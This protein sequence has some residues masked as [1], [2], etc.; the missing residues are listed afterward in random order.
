MVYP[1]ECWHCGNCRIHCPA[2]AVQ[3]LFPLDMLI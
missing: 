2:D 3:Y 1:D